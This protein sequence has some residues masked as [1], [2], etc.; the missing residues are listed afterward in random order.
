MQ[1]IVNKLLSKENPLNV[2]HSRK[3]ITSSLSDWRTATLLC[4]HIH[5]WEARAC[6]RFFQI[7]LM[8]DSFR[9]FSKTL[10]QCLMHL[11]TY[12][13]GYSKVKYVLSL[14][15]AKFV[16][17]LLSCLVYRQIPINIQ[18]KPVGLLV[19]KKSINWDTL[20]H[21]SNINL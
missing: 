18:W 20:V 13:G 21:Q 4:S 2:S 8:P 15:I 10:E 12:K 19:F 3:R 11:Y 14:N 6:T 9:N 17:N 7:F 1:N 16:A 5:I